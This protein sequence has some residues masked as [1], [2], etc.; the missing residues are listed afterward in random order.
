MF[1]DEHTDTAREKR[2]MTSRQ[3]GKIAKNAGGVK[4]MGLFHYSPRY[5]D[6]DLSILLEQAREEFPSTVLTR[7]RHTY[8]IPY[9]E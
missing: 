3:A 9:E 4:Q 7:D 5:T 6:R 2:H 1:D 8:T